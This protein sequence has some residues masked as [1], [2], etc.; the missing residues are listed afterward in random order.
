[1][2]ASATQFWNPNSKREDPPFHKPNP[3][4]RKPATLQHNEIVGL[5]ACV[6]LNRMKSHIHLHASP[7]DE[8]TP[9]ADTPPLQTKTPLPQTKTPLPQTKI[10]LAANQK[11]I[12]AR[13]I[14]SFSEKPLQDLYRS[15]DFQHSLKFRNPCSR[16]ARLPVS[17]HPVGSPLDE[18][19]LLVNNHCRTYTGA[20]ISNILSNLQPSTDR[21]LLLDS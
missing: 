2:H 15:I 17:Q 18:I 21:F 6:S 14:P 10:P 1:M 11:T 4:S 20:S 16:G 7:A 3:P 13:R 5:F 19:S 8:P 12:S 9:P